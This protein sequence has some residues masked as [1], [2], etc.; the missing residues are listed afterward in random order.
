MFKTYV[1]NI[2]ASLNIRSVNNCI[3]AKE[4]AKKCPQ[5]IRCFETHPSI[6]TITKQCL[7]PSFN[8]QKTNP[9]E[10]MKIISQLNTAKTCQNADTPTKIL[11]L[12]KDIFEKFISNNF[13]HCIDEGE[14]PYELKHADVI[15]VHKKKVKCVKENYRPVSILTNISKVYE[16]LWYNQLYSYFDNILSPNQCDF[17]KGHS[18]KQCLLVMIQKFKE[19]IDKGHQFGALLTDLSKAFDCIDHKHLIA[20][21]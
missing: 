1:S 11:K 5:Q 7:S 14:F 21:L 10:V 13:N 18:A 20:K 9:N 4:N 6:T 17:R 3:T 16:T 8:F 15:P 19:S 2:V 12:N